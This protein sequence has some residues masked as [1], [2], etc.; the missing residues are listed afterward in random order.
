MP[1]QVDRDPIEES[2]IGGP[3]REFTNFSRMDREFTTFSRDSNPGSLAGSAAPLP[4]I[5]VF[6]EAFAREMGGRLDSIENQILKGYAH[7]EKTIGEVDNRWEPIRKASDAAAEQIKELEQS[8]K[9]QMDKFRYTVEG[10]YWQVERLVEQRREVVDIDSVSVSVKENQ[11]DRSEQDSLLLHRLGHV[12]RHLQTVCGKLEQIAVQNGE[13]H[14][15]FNDAL[16]DEKVMVK[17]ETTVAMHTAIVPPLS[18]TPA[19]APADGPSNQKLMMNGVD[20]IDRDR[21]ELVGALHN[22]MGYAKRNLHASKPPGREAWQALALSKGFQFVSVFCIFLNGMLT[23]VELDMQV[24]QLLSDVMY[25]EGS[26]TQKPQD[27]DQ[28]VFRGMD[29]VLIAWWSF[30]IGVYSLAQGESFLRVHNPMFMWNCLDIFCVVC[31]ISEF[32]LDI[33]AS[34]ARV[35][36]LRF[37]KLLRIARVVRVM[38]LIHTVKAFQGVRKLIIAVNGALFTLAWA[39][40]LLVVLMYIFTIMLS[41]GIANYYE[42]RIDEFQST[43]PA[44][45]ACSTGSTDAKTNTELVEEFYG[46]VLVTMATLF[47][48][49]TGGDWTVMAEPVF[50]LSLV[51]HGIWYAYV[52]FVIFGLLN[53]FTGIFVESATHAA[54][55]DREIK[56]QAQMEEE[57][58]YLN[59]IRVIFQRS[60]AD[61]SG[62]MTERELEFLLG[63]ED[64]KM[65]MESLGIHTTE[66][67]GL[68]RLLDGDQS[69]VVNIE[70]FLSG[71]V[72]LKGTAKAVDMI[73]LLFENAKL[74]RKVEKIRKMLVDLV[75]DGEAGHTGPA[76]F[77][78]TELLDDRSAN[79]SHAT[80]Y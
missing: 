44:S 67:H 55:S 63:Q 74:S 50:K 66:A 57:E 56:I 24:G 80:S 45:T 11:D 77:E 19:V 32:L 10:T 72:R 20:H 71:C 49:I 18:P 25:R 40:I 15:K 21:H 9:L 51:F 46:G 62:N 47:M 41:T 4:M 3:V 75:D 33:F 70:E 38:R 52:A 43:T 7:I 65:Q 37:V 35:P 54:N 78:S 59:Q 68:F 22:A 23:G 12:E 73:T 17:Q 58:S 5:S 2:T 14:D 13:M 28:T 64:F 36:G 61:Q 16:D 39:L 31:S 1:P 76:R 48:A 8:F 29:C 69:G 26:S 79:G 60:D 42:A 53:V 34:D 6:L 30:E 27:I